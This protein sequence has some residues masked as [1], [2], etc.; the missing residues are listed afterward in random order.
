MYYFCL[1]RNDESTKYNISLKSIEMIEVEDKFQPLC[2]YKDLIFCDEIES[3][4]LAIPYGDDNIIV[5]MLIDEFGNWDDKP[6]N[7]IAT[8]LW[9]RYGEGITDILGHAVLCVTGRNKDG[10]ED[11]CGFSENM[12][13]QIEEC[14]NDI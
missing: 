2:F 12:K 13:R 3:I 14:L 7:T 11:L 6:V 8:R 1:I 4:S 5:R 10:I 9:K